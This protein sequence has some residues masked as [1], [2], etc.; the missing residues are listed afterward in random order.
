M[1]TLIPNDDDLD[2]GNDLLSGAGEIAAYLF[3]DPKKRRR[4]YHL[5]EMKQLPLFYMGATL[6]GR[7]STL[8]KH[9]AKAERA[10]VA[11]AE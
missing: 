3:K 5:N 2:L 10:A 4:V 11:T 1:A 8:K 7:K 6:C 9:I